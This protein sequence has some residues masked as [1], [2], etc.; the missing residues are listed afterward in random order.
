MRILEGDPTRRRL[1]LLNWLVPSCSCGDI[2]F[3]SKVLLLVFIVANSVDD[4]STFNFGI[5]RL[6]MSFTFFIL[7]FT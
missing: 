1:T 6:R 3:T 4:F 2:S 5:K 7:T